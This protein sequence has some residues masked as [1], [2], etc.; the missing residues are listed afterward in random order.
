MEQAWVWYGPVW[1]YMGY[2]GTK[3]SA[4]GMKWENGSIPGFF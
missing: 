1:D 3:W 4:M 2:H